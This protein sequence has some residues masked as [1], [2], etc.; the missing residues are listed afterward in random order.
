M[1][2]ETLTETLSLIDEEKPLPKGWRLETLENLITEAQSGFAIGERDSN[3]AIQLRMNNVTT[4]G[5]FDWTSFIRV[6]TNEETLE[7]YKLRAGDV[8]FNN[9]NSTELVGKTVLFRDHAEPVTFSNH[10][11]RLRTR[12]DELEPGY[13]TH[14]LISQFQQ[15][16]FADICD[17]WIGQSAVQKKKLLA[18]KIPLPPTIEEQ[19]RIA[20]ILDGQMKAVEQA[21]LAVEEQLAAANLLPNA[22]LR[23]VFE[24]EESQ[25]WQKRKLGELC[26]VVR[27]SSPR[28]QGDKRYY[29]GN[30]PRLMVADL[31]RDGMFVTPKIDFL[32]E[33]GAKLSR[34]MK[35]GEVVMAVS[36]NPGLPAILAVDACIHDGFVGLRYL[37]T[38][39]VNTKYLYHLLSVSKN[40]QSQNATGAIFRNL[41]TDQVRAIEIPLPPT[42]EKQ[43]KVV[44]KLNEQ[45]QAV[46]TLKKS[47]IEKLE[48]VK[49]LP[50][51]LLRKAFAG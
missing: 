36:G 29:G 13:L 45:M 28:P 18:L 48:A 46:E 5:T 15:K 2:D 1:L 6:P 39:K 20:S 50:A 8:L 27:G 35:K 24:S 14:W 40:D 17:K 38:N 11:T 9:T 23:S 25:H 30:V 34:P 47:L 44:E 49:K 16:V 7:F 37:D 51:A 4:Q 32:T 43:E 26:E 21:R 31:T 22:F 12:R 42:I 33:E 41:T 19:R 10:F 3:G